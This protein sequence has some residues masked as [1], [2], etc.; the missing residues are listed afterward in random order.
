MMLPVLRRRD[1]LGELANTGAVN[2]RD[3]SAR[4]GVSAI[5]IRRDLAIMDRQ[6]QLIRVRG[7][8][9]AAPGAWPVHR[10]QHCVEGSPVRPR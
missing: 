10:R 3:L 7:G 8:A 4:F 6:G 2:A 1:I 9:V 5:T